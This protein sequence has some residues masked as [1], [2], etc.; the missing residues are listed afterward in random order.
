MLMSASIDQCP[1]VGTVVSQSIHKYR[2]FPTIKEL[3]L[4]KEE[5]DQ[6]LSLAYRRTNTIVKRYN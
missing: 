3:E 4:M 2:E 6:K 1:V 5:Y